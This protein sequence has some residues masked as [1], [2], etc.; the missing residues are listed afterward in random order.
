MKPLAMPVFAA[1]KIGD[2]FVSTFL[3]EGLIIH[4]MPKTPPAL[5][6]GFIHERDSSTSAAREL[7]EETGIKING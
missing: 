2:E 7:F 5:P 3:R 1:M 4:T 6:G